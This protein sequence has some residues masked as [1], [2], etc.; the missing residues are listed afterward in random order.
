MCSVWAKTL[1][2][3][4]NCFKS[5]NPGPNPHCPR[6]N[7]EPGLPECRPPRIQR[8]QRRGS[9]RVDGGW[10]GDRAADL[11]PKPASDASETSDRTLSH[12]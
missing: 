5:Q 4:I 1:P 12:Q 11:K 3:I 10:A 6:P 2:G 7:C 9:F 8:G